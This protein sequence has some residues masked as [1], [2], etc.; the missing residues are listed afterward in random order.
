MTIADNS[1][2]K[3]AK[4]AQALRVVLREEPFHPHAYAA[5]ATIDC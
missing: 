1:P 2:L 5:D 4:L 3:F